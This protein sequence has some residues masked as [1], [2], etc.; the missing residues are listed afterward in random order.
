MTEFRGRFLEEHLPA[1][2]DQVDVKGTWSVI[3]LALG[4]SSPT[5]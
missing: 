4:L 2:S 5:R 1:C 3:Q